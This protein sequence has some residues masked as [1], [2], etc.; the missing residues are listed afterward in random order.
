MSPASAPAWWNSATP[1]LTVTL[2][3][4]SPG[5]PCTANR[6]I[7]A[8]P[9]SRLHCVGQGGAWQD[10]DEFLASEPSQDVDLAERLPRSAGHLPERLVSH[11]MPVGVIH[12]LEMVDV[13]QDHRRRSTKSPGPLQLLCAEF[14]EMA[15]V[16]ETGKVILACKL[17]RLPERGHPF[18][19]IMREN[20]LFIWQEVSRRLGTL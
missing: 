5:S 9:L 19:H 10:R 6:A 3:T 4:S 13:R 11:A 14:E 7:A 2:M 16:V 20:G 15:A 1:T 12:H 18:R 8:R 17:T